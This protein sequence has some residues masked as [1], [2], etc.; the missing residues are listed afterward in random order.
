M[1]GRRFG[2]GWSDIATQRTA[3]QAVLT[4]L[5]FVTVSKIYQVARQRVISETELKQLRRDCSIW[6]TTFEQ[7][8]YKKMTLRGSR[9]ACSTTI[10]FSI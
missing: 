2:K 7:L 3:L 10:P 9:F 5:Q 4:E 8:Y 1:N 6:V